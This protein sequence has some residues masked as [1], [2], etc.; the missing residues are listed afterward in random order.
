MTK[1]SYY[2]QLKPFFQKIVKAYKEDFTVHDRSAL[3]PSKN[4]LW[5][6]SGMRESGTNIITSSAVDDSKANQTEEMFKHT[7]ACAS[8]FMFE[9]GNTNFFICQNNTVKEV[10]K[11]EAYEFL[12]AKTEY[13]KNKAA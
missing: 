3:H 13:G 4:V 7:L 10:S 6:V 8:L 9:G 11:D 5:A 2:M 1:Q 12:K